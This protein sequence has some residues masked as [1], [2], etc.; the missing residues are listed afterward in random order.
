MVHGLRASISLAVVA[1]CVGLSLIPI[2]PSVARATITASSTSADP[3]SAPDETTALSIAHTTGHPIRVDSETTETS[4]VSAQPNGGMQMRIDTVPV[5]AE[6]DGVWSD[7]DASLHTNSDGMFEP[8]TAALPV[9]FG[10]GG[11]SLLDEVQTPGGDWVSE[12]WPFGALPLPKVSGDAA[13]YPEALPGVDI[14]LKATA[15]GMS[16]VL[17]V[18]NATAASD[19]RL[20]AFRLAESGASLAPTATDQVL[21]TVADG[22][23]VAA[24]SPLWWDSTQGGNADGPGGNEPDRPV[25]HV[26]DSSGLSLDIPQTVAGAPSPSPKQASPPTSPKPAHSARRRLLRRS[27]SV[28]SVRRW[29][30]FWTMRLS[31]NKSMQRNTRSQAVSVRPTQTSMR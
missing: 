27:R 4:S 11:S 26:A 31:S 22:T 9:R 3:Q 16:T 28:R 19:S 13:T 14:R 8:K 12:T 1:S 20:A 7:L 21:A 24:G 17:V 18:K 5:R 6:K 25:K 29:T 15:T 2:V 10:A 23:S 30:I